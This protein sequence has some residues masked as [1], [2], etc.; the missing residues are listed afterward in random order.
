MR[1]E[2]ESFAVPIDASA[3]DRAFSWLPWT[4]GVTPTR[5]Q[6]SQ[7]PSNSTKWR[8]F[9]DADIQQE[10]MEINYMLGPRQSSSV[11]LRQCFRSEQ[12][13]VVLS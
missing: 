13:G 9:T 12:A 5:H 7:A 10:L 1:I 4:A 8:S 11:I 2:D 3:I 6:L